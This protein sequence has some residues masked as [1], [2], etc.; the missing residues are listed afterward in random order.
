MRQRGIDDQAGDGNGGA[1]F[2]PDEEPAAVE[3]VRRGAADEG[4]R[5]QG[6]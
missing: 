5:E 4:E 1:R 3:R 6:D 2:R